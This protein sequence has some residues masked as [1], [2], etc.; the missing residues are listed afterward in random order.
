V[1][2]VNGGGY[3]EV[4]VMHVQNDGGTNIQNICLAISDPY[5]G[6]TVKSGCVTPLL[7]SQQGV[8]FHTVSYVDGKIH[9]IWKGGTTLPPAYTYTGYVDFYNGSIMVYTSTNLVTTADSASFLKIGGRVYVYTN[10]IT[11]SIFLA[12]ESDSYINFTSY[13]PATSAVSRLTAIDVTGDGME[14]LFHQYANNIKMY[15]SLLSPE[16]IV[17]TTSYIKCVDKSLNVFG[18]GLFGDTCRSN[19][20]SVFGNSVLGSGIINDNN[21]FQIPIDINGDSY[22]DVITTGTLGTNIYID[23][24]DVP[25][26]IPGD[27]ELYKMVCTVAKD[28]VVA[29]L[30]AKSPDTAIS[31]KVDF[32]DA[33][34]VIPQSYPNSEFRHAYNRVGNY[35]IIGSVCPTSPWACS[36]RKSVG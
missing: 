11:R 24:P 6:G 5:T 10:T 7:Q 15:S 13:I 28:T 20:I 3:K 16:A 22:R 19:S 12:T 30:Y 27:L 21:Q 25:N 35:T 26:L 17:P 14:E 23:N 4:I 36:D 8:A 1:E 29:K 32:G 34:G 18:T 33:T 31:Y 2:D 9:F